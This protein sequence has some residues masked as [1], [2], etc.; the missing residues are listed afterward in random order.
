[1]KVWVVV[2]KRKKGQTASGRGGRARTWTGGAGFGGGS[3]LRKALARPRVLA[4][5]LLTRNG[6]PTNRSG[7]SFE[8]E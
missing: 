5:F 3:P 4:P 6:T 8:I 7:H 2:E 1:M